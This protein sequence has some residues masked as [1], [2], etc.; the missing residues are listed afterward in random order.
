MN[1]VVCGCD[2]EFLERCSKSYRVS[3]KSCEWIE[4]CS[5]AMA[6]LF[7]SL[8]LIRSRDRGRFCFGAFE[9]EPYRFLL[10]GAQRKR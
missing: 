1:G 6:L 2:C 10:F 3:P 4:G 9:E 8:C 7:S 5:I